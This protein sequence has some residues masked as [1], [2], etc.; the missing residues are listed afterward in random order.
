MTKLGGPTAVAHVAYLVVGSAA[1]LAVTSGARARRDDRD[2]DGQRTT[3][4]ASGSKA[5]NGLMTPQQISGGGRGLTALQSMMW[6]YTVRCALRSDQQLEA[7]DAESGAKQ[8]FQGIF[9]VAPEWSAGKCDQGCQEKVSSC[10]IALTN[11][12]GKHVLVSLLSGEPSMGEKLAPN[13]QDVDFPHQEGAFFGNVFSGEAFACRGQGVQKAAQLKRFCASDPATCSGLADFAD[14]GQCQDVCKMKCVKLSDGS[15]RCAASACRDPKGRLWAHPIT[16]YVRNKI[17]AVNADAIEGAWTDKDQRLQLTRGGAAATYEGVDFGSKAG[18][19]KTFAA[20]LAARRAGGRIELW[21]DGDKRIGSLA[22]KGTN[23]LEKE[24]ITAI[25]AAGV[26]GA[27]RV[28]LKFVGDT[29]AVQ[30]STIE[31]R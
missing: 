10:L 5:W 7:T 2:L 6:K 1:L 25:Q 24:Q 12:T 27:H 21:L 18:T 22:V 31:F 4:A 8:M 13:D 17:E 30:L 23:G 20:A 14:A 15:E 9:G 11:R 28:V 26:S 19:V 29:R 3:P 16:S